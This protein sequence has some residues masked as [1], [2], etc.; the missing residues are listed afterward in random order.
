MAWWGWMI[1]TSMAA[2]DLAIIFM[3]VIEVVRW[4]GR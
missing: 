1:V 4:G 2:A 3:C